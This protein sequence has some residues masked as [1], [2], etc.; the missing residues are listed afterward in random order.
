MD[1][2]TDNYSLVVG[3]GIDSNVDEYQVVNKLTGVIEYNDY[4]LPRSI[5]ALV[6]LQ[7]KL[8]EVESSFKSGQLKL[9]LVESSEGSVH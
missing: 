5:E 2:D 7:E 3:A 9:S 6:N 1:Y 4:I 8:D